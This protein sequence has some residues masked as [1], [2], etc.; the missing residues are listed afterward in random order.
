MKKW[1]ILESNIK[2]DQAFQECACILEE[3]KCMVY[4]YGVGIIN[5]RDLTK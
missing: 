5:I 1:I 2:N 3:D 4:V